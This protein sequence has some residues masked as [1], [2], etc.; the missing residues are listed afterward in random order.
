M[1]SSE[2]TNVEELVK[3]K[4]I[5]LFDGECIMCDGTVKFIL[6]RDPEAKISFAPL[7]SGLFFLCL[8]LF[9]FLFSCSIWTE[10]IRRKRRLERKREKRKRSEEK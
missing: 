1:S 6:E 10:P 8:F 3:E 9:L 7:Q 2:T 5:L 4:N